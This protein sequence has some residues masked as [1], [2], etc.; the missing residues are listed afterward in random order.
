MAANVAETGR[1]EQRIGDRMQ[2]G[3]RIGV[4][5]LSNCSYRAQAAEKAREGKAGSEEE[6]K[7]AAALVAQG[8]DANSDLH[9]SAAV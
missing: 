9:A 8:A 1:A 6:I 7:A 3:V 4:T 2:Q 5:G